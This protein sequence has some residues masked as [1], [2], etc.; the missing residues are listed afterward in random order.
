MRKMTKYVELKEGHINFP[1]NLLKNNV[2]LTKMLK[3][4]LKS[5]VVHHTKIVKSK[6][7]KEEKRKK[8]KEGIEKNKFDI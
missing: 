5:L 3:G 8:L 7:L 6:R 4:F 2:H 1:V